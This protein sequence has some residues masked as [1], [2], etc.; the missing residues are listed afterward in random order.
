MSMYEQRRIVLQENLDRGKTQLERNKLGQ[1]GTPIS[2]ARDIITYGIKLLP[3]DEPIRFF[4]PA[5]GTGAFFSRFKGPFSIQAQTG[6]NQ[7][8]GQD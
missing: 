1:F 8:S 2:L 7:P 4:D 5:V 6:G 3:D